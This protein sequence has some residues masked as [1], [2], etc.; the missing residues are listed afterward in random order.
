MNLVCKEFIASKLDKTGVLIL[1][2]MAGASKEFSDAILI[3]PNDDQMAGAIYQALTMP[4]EEQIIHISIMQE[5][6][7]RYNIHHWVSIF[8]ER[9]QFIK[10]SQKSMAT[11]KLD[12]QAIQEH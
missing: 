7:K 1:S 10:D 8:M 5:T 3:N 12:E 9:L 6:L 2:E 4:E 11:K